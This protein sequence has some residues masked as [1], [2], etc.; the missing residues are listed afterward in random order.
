MNINSAIIQKKCV[1]QKWGGT[2]RCSSCVPTLERSIRIYVL[3][4]YEVSHVPNFV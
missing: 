2:F 3:H 1:A 4:P